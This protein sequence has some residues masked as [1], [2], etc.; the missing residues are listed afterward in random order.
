MKNRTIIILTA[1]M[2]DCGYVAAQNVDRQS[3][4]QDVKDYRDVLKI[5]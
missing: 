1:L 3:P 2:L 5:N 4:G